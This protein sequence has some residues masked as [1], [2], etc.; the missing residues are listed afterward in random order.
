MSDELAIINQVI[1]E[2]RKVRRHLKLAGD[3]LTDR[4]AIA[5]LQKARTDWVPGR[6]EILAEKQK[7]LQQTVSALEEGLMHHFSYEEKNLPPILGELLTRT[8]LI[9]HREIR[10]G[11]DDVKNV[12]SGSKL[13]GLNR[14]QCLI[15]ESKMHDFIN[16]LGQAIDEHAHREEIILDMIQRALQERRG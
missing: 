15:E 7:K 2:H 3:S 1:E 16:N 5:S 10:K 12:I 8:L 9:E 14:E 4:E 13:E 6:L 11:L